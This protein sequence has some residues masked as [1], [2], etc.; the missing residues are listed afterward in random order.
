MNLKGYKILEAVDILPQIDHLHKYGWDA[1]K[2]VGF[3]CFEKHYNMLP[4]S[5]TDWTGYPQSGKTEMVLELMLNTTEFYGWKHLIFAPDI[6]KSIE[7]MAK[8]IHK[9][10][11]FTFK[12][13]YSNF[14]S[15]Q[16]AYKAN[17]HLLEHFKI[18]HKTE[19][20]QRSLTPIELWEFAAE[21][22]K[23]V[24]INTV[25]LDSWK[26]MYHDYKT[27]GGN[28]AQYLS[29]VL[30]VRN[31]IAE[32]SGLH[33]HT[34]IHPKTPVRDKNRTIYAP[35]FD[36]MEGGAQWN[37]SGKC[38]IAVHRAS[39]DDNQT[40][41][42]FRKIKPESVGRPT[43]MAVELFLDYASSRY[44]EKMEGS[45]Y[46][47]KYFARQKEKKNEAPF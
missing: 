43:S 45:L 27:H 29:N 8:L 10:S 11:G 26:D 20:K 39:F 18:I 37:N 2:Y 31:E 15:I 24:P 12:K 38:I 3:E 28:Y 1:G 14:I 42:Y 16:E 44:Y 33:F 19:Y 30:P 6:G 32:V 5:C 17:T 47:T 25:L 22:N 34:V 13:K 7:I 4:G 9:Y 46:D 21:Y 41:V 36:D 23:E 40:D 35:S